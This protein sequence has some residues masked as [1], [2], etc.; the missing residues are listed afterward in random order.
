MVDRTYEEWQAE[1]EEYKRT[2][3]RRKPNTS[4]VVAHIWDSVA[5]PVT[6]ESLIPT[7]QTAIARFIQHA[8]TK[9][10]EESWRLSAPSKYSKEH[11]TP[12]L[13][14]ALREAADAALQLGRNG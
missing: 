14:R 11:V 9:S 1:L 3:R 10:Y 12:E 6:Y 2:R 4:S 13:E 8:R 5:P 7:W